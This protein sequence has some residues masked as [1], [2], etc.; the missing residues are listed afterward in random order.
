MALFG[1]STG[2]MASHYTRAADRKKLAQ[3]AARMLLPA[4]PENEK[5]PH[6]GSGAGHKPKTRSGRGA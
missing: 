2:K 3:E 4:Q 6:L 5:R 1:W